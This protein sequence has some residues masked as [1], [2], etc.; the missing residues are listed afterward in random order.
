MKEWIVQGL[1]FERQAGLPLSEAEA[2]AVVSSLYASWHP[3]AVQYARRL[4]GRLD[5]AEDTVQEVFLDL[6]RALLGGQPVYNPKAWVLTALRIQVRVRMGVLREEAARFS[7]CVEL[8]RF[9]AAMEQR[10]AA[11]EDLSVLAGI[12]TAREREVLFLR[13]AEMRYRE[14]AQTLGI[15]SSSV[16]TLL[17]RALKK[18]QTAF[19]REVDSGSAG[20]R[21]EKNAPKV[22]Q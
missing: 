2:C 12:L 15:S 14:I 20:A 7:S 1:A 3:S 16:N 8:D 5:V 10:V 19:R 17:A 11:A 4:T 18:L 6:Y 13:L 9:P 22:L 21:A